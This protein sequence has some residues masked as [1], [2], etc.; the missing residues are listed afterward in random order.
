MK[1]VGESIVDG[2]K[3]ACDWL[4]NDVPVDRVEADGRRTVSSLVS[5]ISTAATT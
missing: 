1:A 4:R 2:N 3:E 5:S